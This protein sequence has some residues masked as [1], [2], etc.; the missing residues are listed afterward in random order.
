MTCGTTFAAHTETLVVSTIALCGT[1]L[2]YSIHGARRR[3]RAWQTK[4]E[5]CGS[6]TAAVGPAASVASRSY[7]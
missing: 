2:E 5:V 7:G 4:P 3:A 1:S 6:S